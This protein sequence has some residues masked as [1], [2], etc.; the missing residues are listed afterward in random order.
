LTLKEL[1]K[2]GVLKGA[3]QTITPITHERYLTLKKETGID[4]CFT[5]N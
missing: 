2:T 3:P 1:K 5:C 4:E